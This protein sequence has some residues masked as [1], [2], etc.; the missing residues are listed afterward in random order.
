MT[1]PEEQIRRYLD[2]HGR[3]VVVPFHNLLTTWGIDEPS[4]ADRHMI[5]KALAHVGVVASPSVFDTAPNDSMTLSSM[6]RPEER[7]R[8]YLDEHG[9]TVEIPFHNLL[10]TWNLDEV[11]DAD[12]QLIEE[13]L[14]R[15]AVVA[16][17]SLRGVWAGSPV[18]LS[19]VEP[20]PARLAKTSAGVGTLSRPRGM[21]PDHPRPAAPVVTSDKPERTGSTEGW[22]Q[23]LQALR[24][25]DPI[26]LA[27]LGLAVIVAVAMVAVNLGQSLVAADENGAVK[28]TSTGQAMV[29]DGRVV[30]L[31]GFAAILVL[32]GVAIARVFSRYNP[33][34]RGY[35]RSR[36]RLGAGLTLASRG[37]EGGCW[38]VHAY[39]ILGTVLCLATGIGW[40]VLIYELLLRGRGPKPTIT[41]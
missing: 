29:S 22:L 9:R 10:A 3:T 5:R 31:V 19:V 1:R 34:V 15:A 30:A 8:R 18:R 11:T 16:E 25:N 13:A 32:S 26:G 39:R 21:T 37:P 12:R 23:E 14:S 28:K 24:A 33:Q 4:R 17:P 38:G 27:V 7:V 36:G 20:G 6:T 2:E 35:W 41:C 40:A